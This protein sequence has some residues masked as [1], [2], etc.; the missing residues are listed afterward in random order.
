MWVI[1]GISDELLPSQGLCSMQSVRYVPQ[2]PTSTRRGASLGQT[3]CMFLQRKKKT[4]MIHFYFN[5]TYTQTIPY[6]VSITVPETVRNPALLYRQSGI[7]RNG[8]LPAE[9]QQ[10][11]WTP[12]RYHR[13]YA[14]LLQHIFLRSGSFDSSD[15]WKKWS[16]HNALLAAVQRN[17]YWRHRKLLKLVANQRDWKYP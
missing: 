10:S 14:V 12:L 5:A 17:W 4:R 1:S 2:T 13:Q 9:Q 7:L 8:L 15:E 16:E 6:T 11:C 3:A